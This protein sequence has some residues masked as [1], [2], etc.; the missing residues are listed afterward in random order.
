MRQPCETPL[1][2]VKYQ[3]GMAILCVVCACVQYGSG[4]PDDDG[5][6][7]MPPVDAGRP[8]DGALFDGPGRVDAAP[9]TKCDLQKPFGARGKLPGPI[10]DAWYPSS[11]AVSRDGLTMFVSMTFGTDPKPVRLGV[12]S[13][14]NTTAAWQAP[15]ALNVGINAAVESADP[16]LS[17]DG[18][19]LYYAAGP[20]FFERELYVAKRPNVQ[21]EFSTSAKIPTLANLSHHG[22]PSLTRDGTSLCFQSVRSSG[23]GSQDIWCA[24]INAG[25][26]GQAVAQNDLNTPDLDACPILTEDGLGIYF[27]STR[28]PSLGQD[29]WHSTR[30]TLTA[31]WSAPRAVTELNT[32]DL[33]QPIWISDDNCTLY[34]GV[35]KD[36]SHS[37]W[38]VTR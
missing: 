20:Q 35:Q 5:G 19:S 28:S 10:N 14:I 1:A 37:V 13:R 36:V 23:K 30:P 18:L 21:S 31:P 22:R 8:S 26:V 12:T 2:R 4:F 32:P 33:E 16:A 17:A 24:S 9:M 29:I 3:R 25:V 34:L 6:L 11:A 15:T 27:A 38:V 7:W